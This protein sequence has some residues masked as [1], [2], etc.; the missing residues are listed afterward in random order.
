MRRNRV[1]MSRQVREEEVRFQGNP[2]VPFVISLVAGILIIAG[3][4]LGLLSTST[5]GIMLFPG[6][7]TLIVLSSLLELICGLI[8]FTMAFVMYVL[9]K[10]SFHFGTITIVFSV[11]SL[12]FSSVGF[13]LAGLLLGVLGG[14]LAVAWKPSNIYPSSRSCLFEISVECPTR[15]VDP[16]ISITTLSENVCPVCPIRIRM[17]LMGERPVKLTS[18]ES[19]STV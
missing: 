19:A 13:F 10:Y 3:G 9:P 7:T 2:R 4:I 15:K 18:S 1:K 17:G 8:I 5:F 11:I 14:S 16:D 12:F 6:L